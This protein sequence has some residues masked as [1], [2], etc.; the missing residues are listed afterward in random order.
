MAEFSQVLESLV[1]GSSYLDGT[2]N[3][4][5]PRRSGEHYKYANQSVSHSKDVIRMIYKDLLYLQ[6][7]SLVLGSM[8]FYLHQ[9]CRPSDHST[10][11]HVSIISLFLRGWLLIST[12]CIRKLIGLSL[13]G[14]AYFIFWR[15]ELL[16]L[17]VLPLLLTTVL[18]IEEFYRFRFVS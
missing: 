9:P 18:I 10:R 2:F 14:T 6:K 16:A 1:L 8:G 7:S 15:P 4:P 11:L 12:S 13:L 3:P 5:D 17:R